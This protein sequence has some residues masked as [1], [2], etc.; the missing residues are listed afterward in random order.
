MR[1]G[2][3]LAFSVAL[4]TAACVRFLKPRPAPE[5]PPA[6]YSGGA[7]TEVRIV[8]E[9]A[10]TAEVLMLS[11]PKKRRFLTGFIEGYVTN[12]REEPVPRVRV[13]VRLEAAPKGGLLRAFGEGDVVRTD[14]NGLY[15]ISFKLELV[16][17]RAEVRGALRYGGGYDQPCADPESACVKPREP[18]RPF[19][20]AFDEESW[21]VVFVAK[22]RAA[23][24]WPIEGGATKEAETGRGP[25]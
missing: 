12:L 10:G 5:G 8:E 7:L 20:L 13:D 25:R 23:Y 9:S 11:V 24:S 3:A 2:I 14:S 15:R 22:H 6:D 4:L 16:G 17:G 18:E 19:V 1:S 21:R